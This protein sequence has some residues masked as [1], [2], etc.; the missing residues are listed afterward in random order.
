[1]ISEFD[2]FRTIIENFLHLPIL[3]TFRIVNMDVAQRLLQ[4]LSIYKD[5]SE[6]IATAVKDVRQLEGAGLNFLRQGYEERRRK[7][8]LKAVTLLAPSDIPAKVVEVDGVD[9]A[10]L[11]ISRDRGWLESALAIYLRNELTSNALA[12]ACK[13]KLGEATGHYAHS[14]IAAIWD[15]IDLGEERLLECV[16]PQ[17]YQCKESGRQIL[18]NARAFCKKPYE[19]QQTGELNA[20]KVIAFEASRDDHRRFALVTAVMMS[21][22][23]KVMFYDR[24]AIRASDDYSLDPSAHDGLDFAIQ[25]ARP[26]AD[27]G[28]SWL[29]LSALCSM[30]AEVHK[31]NEGVRLVNFIVN[32][33]GLGLKACKDRLDTLDGGALATWIPSK[34]DF[35]QIHVRN[36]EATRSRVQRGFTARMAMI[37]GIKAPSTLD[38]EISP[39]EKLWTLLC[40]SDPRTSSLGRKLVKAYEDQQILKIQTRE[41]GSSSI[42]ATYIY[43]TLGRTVVAEEY[44]QIFSN[45][46]VN[47]R[48]AKSGTLIFVPHSGIVTM[49]TYGMICKDIKVENSQIFSYYDPNRFALLPHLLEILGL[50]NEDT[51]L[52]ILVR[53]MDENPYLVS[54]PLTFDVRACITRIFEQSRRE[55]RVSTLHEAARNAVG[56]E[57]YP[58][59]VRE[60]VS[61]LARIGAGVP[62][63]YIGR[64]CFYDITRDLKQYKDISSQIRL[65]FD[66]G[67]TLDGLSCEVSQ[68]GTVI[69]IHT[70]L[71]TDLESQTAFVIAPITRQNL[72]RR[73]E[74]ELD[75]ETRAV[76]AAVKEAGLVLM[77][78]MFNVHGELRLAVTRTDP[79]RGIFAL[80]EGCEAR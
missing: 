16:K 60:A 12:A 76:E 23:G 29:P 53:Q 51:L 49:T 52:S 13:A 64:S 43:S 69:S 39:N 38:S 15:H 78:P 20:C 31:Q 44:R 62:A 67:V 70:D 30:F 9:D 37:N 40:L 3:R 24:G 75:E 17:V 46:K 10:E 41:S 77:R 19:L 72:T 47:I 22:S 35:H 50:R 8:I 66:R 7:L 74:T 45:G 32:R 80:L 25:E 34:S 11:I 4:V 42:F 55:F 79:S 71:H 14:V 21:A 6:L 65:L 68:R 61:L 57:D 33:L 1:M 26:G 54:D 27:N 5:N 18:E 28:V 73:P 36:D 59:L 63:E 56:S 48:R 58:G 2:A